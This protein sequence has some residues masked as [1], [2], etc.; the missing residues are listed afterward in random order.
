MTGLLRG[1]QLETAAGSNDQRTVRRRGMRP[2]A[3]SDAGAGVQQSRKAGKADGRAL[4]WAVTT[5][6]M[7]AS[8]TSSPLFFRFRAADGSKRHRRQTC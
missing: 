8:V 6:A 7:S 3:V 5:A 2:L 4:L 1:T